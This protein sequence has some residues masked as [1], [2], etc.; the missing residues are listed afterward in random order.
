VAGA[1]VVL[2]DGVGCAYLERAGKGLVALR[3][4]D[5]TWE[6]VVAGALAAMLAAGRWRRLVLQRTPEQMTAVLT[7]AGF[8][9]GPKGLVL[10]R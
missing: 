4:P 3:E 9:P 5:G 7:A 1:Y 2:V 8:V 10:Y 6:E